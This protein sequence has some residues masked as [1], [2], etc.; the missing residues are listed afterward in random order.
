MRE[1]FLI[2]INQENIV[3]AIYYALNTS[4]GDIHIYLYILED[5]V[6]DLNNQM[7]C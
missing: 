2:V 7:I 3:L 1:D 4:T 5:F 6:T